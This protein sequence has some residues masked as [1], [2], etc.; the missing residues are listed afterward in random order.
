MFDF[1]FIEFKK[2]CEIHLALK[3][4]FAGHLFTQVLEK[5]DLYFFIN[6]PLVVVAVNDFFVFVVVVF[7]L[8]FATPYRSLIHLFQRV[9]TK[10]YALFG[11]VLTYNLLRKMCEIK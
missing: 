7:F 5:N 1:Q 4:F 3:L 9:C 11:E 6:P 10:F 8:I 2:F